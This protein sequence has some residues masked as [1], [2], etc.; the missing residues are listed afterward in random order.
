MLHISLW[1]LCIV[2]VTSYRRSGPGN[3]GLYPVGLFS[4]Q[5]TLWHPWPSLWRCC[6]LPSPCTRGWSV[7]GASNVTCWL[8][9]TT[10]VWPSPSMLCCSADVAGGCWRESPS[11]ST[12]I[13]WATVPPPRGSSVDWGCSCWASS[14]LVWQ[15]KKG[16]TFVFVFLYLSVLLYLYLNHDQTPWQRPNLCV[17]MCFLQLGD[18]LKVFWQ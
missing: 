10:S 6:C 1:S 8:P 18:D 2:T 4:N 17:F 13:S 12:C 14:Y 7:S 5:F 3:L 15:N 16:R 9:F 11:I